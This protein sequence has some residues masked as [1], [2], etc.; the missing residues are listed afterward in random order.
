MLCIQGD[1]LYLSSPKCVLCKVI[2]FKEYSPE[3]E[4]NEQL[5]SEENWQTPDDQMIK[6]NNNRDESCG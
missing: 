4:E 5:Y 6:I 1:G 3:K 2:S